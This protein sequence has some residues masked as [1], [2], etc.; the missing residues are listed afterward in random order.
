M[1]NKH[2]QEASTF[3]VLFVILIIKKSLCQPQHSG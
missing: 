2:L 1:L 3:F